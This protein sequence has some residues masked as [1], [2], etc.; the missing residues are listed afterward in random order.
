MKRAFVKWLIEKVFKT[1]IVSIVVPIKFNYKHYLPKDGRWHHIAKT[2][3]FWIK[4]GKIIESEEDH[5]MDGNFIDE[6]RIWDNKKTKGQIVINKN[7]QLKGTENN[8]QS[9]WSFN[10]MNHP[11][12]GKGKYG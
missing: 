9:Y 12:G 2:V 7:R 1:E 4:D 6:V 5:Y 3:E 8:L 10:H 11:R